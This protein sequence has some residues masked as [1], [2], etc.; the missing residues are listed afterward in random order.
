V[1]T[2]DEPARCPPQAH[3]FVRSK[4]PWLKLPMGVQIFDEY[5]D[6]SKT[7][8]TESLARYQAA[9]AARAEERALARA[10]RARADA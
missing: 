10:E 5:Y 2:L 8:P 4:Q 9:E 3:I 7:W 1:G 6:A